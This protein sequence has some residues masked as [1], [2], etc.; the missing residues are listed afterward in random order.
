MSDNIEIGDV[1]SRNQGTANKETT[2]APN[3]VATPTGGISLENALLGFTAS[4]SYLDEAGKAYSEKLLQLLA[5]KSN[6]KQWERRVVTTGTCEAH[7]F[8][9][10]SYAIPLIFNDSVSK[11]NDRPSITVTGEVQRAFASSPMS[12]AQSLTAELQRPI[13]VTKEDYPKVEIMAQHICNAFTGLTN[14]QVAGM[15]LQNIAVDSTCSFEVSTNIQEVRNYVAKVSP[16]GIPARDDVGILVYL[17][18]LKG[19]VSDLAD[20]SDRFEYIPVLAMTGYTQI[21]QVSSLDAGFGV[22]NAAKFMPCTVITDCVSTLK[23][24]MIV[25]MAMVFAADVLIK[26]R[27]WLSQFNS[28]SE[29][30]PNIGRL[31]P[32]PGKNTPWFAKDV[33]QRNE[34]MK[35]YFASTVPS[36]AFDIVEGRA[37]IPAMDNMI[38]NPKKFLDGIAGFLGMNVSFA[39]GMSPI[40][41]HF[42][43]YT[44]IV[45]VS[46]NMVDTKCID[47]LRMTIDNQNITDERIQRLLLQTKDLN[48]SINNVKSFY[49]NTVESLYVN[50]RCVLNP[51]FVEALG[52]AMC[53]VEPLKHVSYGTANASNELSLAALMG[54]TN[55]NGFVGFGNNYGSQNTVNGFINW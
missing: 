29:K 33:T 37:R 15:T 23:N 20:K 48:S 51:A 36:L 21:Y 26:R 24:N 8:M 41:F 14:G 38:N 18:R 55:Y 53:V 32:E 50:Y 7:V 47:Y 35:Q 6:T 39:E 5:I 44:G 30:E 42:E 16:H 45:G 2:T 4:S 28:F 34:F 31:I 10:G 19:Q 17:R 46:G 54:S 1:R 52:A 12:G 43:E 25:A 3:G 13:L 49:P 40:N 22:N 9:N 11:R 27:S